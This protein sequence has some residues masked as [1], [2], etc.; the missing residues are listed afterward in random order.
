MKTTLPPV[1]HRRIRL[2]LE[3]WLSKRKNQRLPLR[4]DID[5]FDFPE[6]L[7][8]VL[9]IEPFGFGDFRIRLAGTVY[10]EIYGRDITGL[11]LGD[12]VP[13]YGEGAELYQDYRKAMESG[14]PV[15]GERY[16]TWRPTGTPIRYQRI[17]LPLTRS[18]NTVD[19]LLGV[20]VCLNNDGSVR[21]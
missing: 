5:P 16:M 19:F 13:N 10:S 2:A 11:T 6:L 1:A 12:L 15:F 4:S 8:T 18:G 20:G 21:Y 17:L 7:P 3:Y 9:L 14:E